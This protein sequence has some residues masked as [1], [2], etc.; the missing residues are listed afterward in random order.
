MVELI[1]KI[2]TIDNMKILVLIAIACICLI[3]VVHDP[4]LLFSSFN[5]KYYFTFIAIALEF[6]FTFFC[7]IYIIL[8]FSFA[9][10]QGLANE[11]IILLPSTLI[12]VLILIL[13]S[14]PIFWAMTDNKLLIELA[15]SKY[16]IQT[17]FLVLISFSL[18]FSGLIIGKKRIL[19]RL[20]K[21]LYLDRKLDFVKPKT[22]KLYLRTLIALSALVFPF[23]IGFRTDIIFSG[24]RHYII[25]SELLVTL[26]PLAGIIA[27]I[28]TIFAGICYAKSN[29]WIVLLVPI[30]DILPRLIY[31]SR[32][33]FLPI[34]LFTLSS[35]LLGKYLPIWVYLIVAPILLLL[36]SAAVSSRGTSSGGLT[37]IESGI[38]SVQGDY[39]SSFRDFFETNFNLGILSNAVAFHN[40]SLSVYDGFVSWLLTVLPLPSF[41]KLPSITPPNVHEL[42][43]IGGVGIPMPVIG[44]LYFW[45]GWTGTLIF[46]LF[47]WWIGR[48]EGNIIYQTKVC[49]SAYWTHILIW[50]SALYCFILSFHSASRGSSRVLLY[51]VAFIWLLELIVSIFFSKNKS[52]AWIKPN[53]I[54]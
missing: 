3:F 34:I 41:L 9:K 2:F 1:I 18:L 10:K 39:L 51:A 31:L 50:L 46:F 17:I 15:N 26:V 23:T 20:D 30:I 35:S 37:G 53:T 5:K 27:S 28:C 52:V 25:N 7:F 21:S 14:I 48:L 32:G 6:I 49:G 54:S 4:V 47:G 11:Q 45:M 22:I 38:S 42:L 36:G 43:G 13:H 19:N 8:T 40:K 24:G 33:F 44:E 16:I 29:Q 12:P